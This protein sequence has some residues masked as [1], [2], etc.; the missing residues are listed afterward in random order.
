MRILKL[1]GKIRRPVWKT[2]CPKVALILRVSCPYLEGTR[3]AQQHR[4][5]PYRETYLASERQT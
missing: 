3:I 2:D 5:L 4:Q 1:A